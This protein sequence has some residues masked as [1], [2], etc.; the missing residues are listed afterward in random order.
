MTKATLILLS[1]LSALSASAG[2]RETFD[3][4]WQ[5]KYFGTGNPPRISMASASSSE[6]A[7]P[8][9]NAIDGNPQ[10]RW[11]A[12]NGNQGHSLTIN[13]GKAQAVKTIEILWENDKT[14]TVSLKTNNGQTRTADKQAGATKLSLNGK[15]IKSVSIAVSGLAAGS[16]ASIREV[17]FRDAAGKIIKPV[18][19]AD[20][21]P[22]EARLGYKTDG[23]K[24]VQLPHDWAI[25]TPFITTEPNETGMLQ[26]NGYGWYRKSFD[27]PKNFSAENDR[28]YLDFDGVMANP[29]V[30]VNGKLAGAWAFGYNSFRVDI[31][32][33]LKAGKNLVAVE[34]S[35]KVLSTRWY[36]GAGIYRHTWLEKTGPVHLA[37]WGVYVTTPEIS[38]DQATVQV[39]TTVDNTS[40]KESTVTIQQSVRNIE[41]ETLTVKIPAKSSKTVTQKLILPKPQLWDTA[42]PH[43]YQLVT[44]VKQD[45]KKIDDKETTFGVRTVEWRKDGFFLNGRHVRLH[46]VC[47]HHDLGALG[48]AFYADGMERKIEILKEMGCNS[49]R[50]AHNPPASELLDLCDKHG[51]LVIDELFDIWK[52]QKYGKTNGYHVYWPEWWKKDVE[53]FVKR[54]RNHPSVV[55]WSGGNEI[56][57][58]NSAAGAQIS[59]ELR[60]EMKKYDPSRLY[61]V[62]CNFA[63]AAWNEFGKSMDSYGY[64]Y[65][66]GHYAEFVK[67]RP[68]MSF[69]ASETSSCVGTRDTYFFPLSWDK[70]QGFRNFQVSAYG[71]Y[72]P[73]WANCPDVEFKAQDLTPQVA[74][75]Y[76]WTGHDYIGEPTPYNQDLS[77]INNFSGATEEEKKKAM[78][79]LKRMGNKA[80]SRSSYFGIIDLA[81]FPKDTFYLYQSRWAPQVKQ[82]HIL[83]HWNWAGRE[84]EVTPVMVFTSGDEGELF[85]NGK[86]QGVRKKSPTAGGTFEQSGVT[87]GKNEYRLTWEGVKYEP[88]EVK[89]VVKKDGKP[90]A[91]ATRVTTG[92]SAKVIADSD[93]KT[94]VGDGRDLAYIELSLADAQG[95]VVPTDSR[96]VRFSVVGDAGKLIGFC[97]GDPLDHNS[98]QALQ[99]R[100][101]NGRLVAILRG[102]RG[103]SGAVSVK[104]EAEGLPTVTVPVTIMP[105]TS[106]QLKK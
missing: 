44:T 16:W 74:G 95:Y 53:N 60:D 78:A 46:G 24:S 35:N 6:G 22:K 62:G 43:L 52:Y 12:A 58:Q 32:P 77:N 17:I 86:S 54:D 71:L 92:E 1:G 21:A 85:I 99:Q 49:I 93:K 70:G 26:W 36:P 104:I 73:G 11:C 15:P 83:P 100:F 38:K 10:T 9:A 45:G 51:I 3:F 56:E 4:G 81:G 96:K 42:T 30:Y 41:S 55:I 14:K 84:G 68:E 29:Q 105:A 65:K 33:Y 18:K 76:V 57:E 63:H 27:V 91:T 94:L 88:G 101:F 90:W 7:N 102:E 50:T 25:E 106:E 37:Q 61:T 2:E 8:A 20:S 31:T 79:E 66:P 89:V 67:R 80:P 39:Q 97:N 34:V 59:R 87:V 48:A 19:P 69:Y 72:S 5:F 23:F 13:L 40:D 64:N 98:M 82:A 75:E 47:E 103:K 28:Y